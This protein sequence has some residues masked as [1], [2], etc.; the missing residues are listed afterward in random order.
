M[1]LNGLDN[2]DV[3]EAYR[4]ALAEGGRWYC[5]VESSTWI[6]SNAGFSGSFSNIAHGMR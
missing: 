5:P 4:L 3:A 1:S 6:R 2:Q